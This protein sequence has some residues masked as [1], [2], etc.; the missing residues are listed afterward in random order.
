MR[1]KRGRLGYICGRVVVHYV[2]M[3]FRSCSKYLKSYSPQGS[4]QESAQLPVGEPET[5]IPPLSNSSSELLSNTL[6]TYIP[7]FSNSPNASNSSN[8]IG[9]RR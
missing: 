2:S 7:S 8:S 4:L 1:K 3:F 9:L 6:V 5:G